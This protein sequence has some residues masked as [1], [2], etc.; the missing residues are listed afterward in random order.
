MDLV[1]LIATLLCELWPFAVG[2]SLLLILDSISHLHLSAY[3]LPTGPLCLP[4]YPSGSVDLGHV[5]ALL[6][7]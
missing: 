7:W 5:C 1:H 2:A 6:S 4:I 3:Y